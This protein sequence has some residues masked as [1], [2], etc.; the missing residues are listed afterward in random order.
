MPIEIGMYE[1]ML[2]RLLKVKK[3]LFYYITAGTNIS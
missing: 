1:E 2:T 3:I